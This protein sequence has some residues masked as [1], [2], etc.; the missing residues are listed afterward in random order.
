[1]SKNEDKG[2]HEW[3]LQKAEPTEFSPYKKET[4]ICESFSIIM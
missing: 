3:T 4:Q 1:M 2:F